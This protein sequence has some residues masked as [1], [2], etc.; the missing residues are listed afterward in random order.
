MQPKAA[1][2]AAAMRAGAGAARRVAG[3]TLVELLI[4]VAI[5]GVLAALAVPAYTDYAIRSKVAEAVSLM[6]VARTAVDVYYSEHAVLPAKTVPHASLGLASAGSY[7]GRYVSS[8]AVGVPAAGH[9]TVTLNS[10]SALGTAAGA[11][12]I[13]AP[14]VSGGGIEWVVSTASSVAPK[15]RPGRRRGHHGRG[16]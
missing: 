1:S 12:L 16:H 9:I 10:M 7:Q 15:Y 4:V 2:A 14:R 3:F 13:Y 8:V 5:T 6:T 11:T